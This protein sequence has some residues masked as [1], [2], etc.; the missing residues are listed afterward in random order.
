MEEVIRCPVLGVK[1]I[2]AVHGFLINMMLALVAIWTAWHAARLGLKALVYLVRMAAVT[3]AVAPGAYAAEKAEA[4]LPTRDLAFDFDGKQGEARLF[5]II[6]KD[7]LVRTRV[8][9]QQ[10]DY[11]SAATKLGR[12]LAKT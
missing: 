3:I 7:R 9:A 12:H 2:V 6:V 8:A 11:A 5:N 4:A 1:R 10:Q